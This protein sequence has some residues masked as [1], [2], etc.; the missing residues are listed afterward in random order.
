MRDVTVKEKVNPIRSEVEGKR[1]VLVDDSVVRGT[2]IKRIV[3]M[4][5]D[6]GAKEVHV[7]I[8]TP[9]LISPCYLGID[10]T[11]R[12]QFIAHERN[13]AEIRKVINA[14]SLG[15]I[16]IDGLVEA[17]QFS[18]NELC[19]GCVTEEYPIDIPPEKHRFQHT[20]QE[21]D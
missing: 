12:D 4:V 9:P 2:T 14:D 20:L 15:Y 5:R 6:A 8:G 3:D 10:M 11:T 18:K 21:Y 17:L 13:V 19:L 1:V 16:S 7:R